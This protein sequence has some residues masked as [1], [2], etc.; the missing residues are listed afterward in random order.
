[1]EK[2][3]AEV[4][5]RSLHSPGYPL[6]R[7]VK[8]FFPLPIW[9]LPGLFP[10]P[11]LWMTQNLNTRAW[12]FWV[13]YQKI[14]RLSR[15]VQWSRPVPW[16]QD[17]DSQLCRQKR[18]CPFCSWW[19][20]SLLRDL[21]LQRFRWSVMKAKLF[22]DSPSSTHLP[23]HLHRR[24]LPSWRRNNSFP[25]PTAGNPGMWDLFFA[26]FDKGLLHTGL[27]FPPGR[28]GRWLDSPADPAD[29]PRWVAEFPIC[30]PA[31][32]DALCLRPLKFAP[33]LTLYCGSLR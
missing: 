25:A 3:L 31:I 21:H 19:C 29:V 5:C 17:S 32:S 22:W 15:L 24:V 23:R 10:A 2:F 8:D 11:L 28:E 33:L 14:W 27:L 26:A 4:G 30:C 7:Q 20:T 12:Q 16:R 18:M 9:P 6:Q 13:P 1:M